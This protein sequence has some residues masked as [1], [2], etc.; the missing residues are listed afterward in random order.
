VTSGGAQNLTADTA[1]ADQNREEAKES[2]TLPANTETPATEVGDATTGDAD[3]HDSVDPDDEKAIDEPVESQDFDAVAPKGGQKWKRGLACGV[4]PGL[5]LLLAL[6]AGF[7][8][9]QDSSI[10]AGEVAR[11]ESMQVAKDATVRLLSYRPDTVDEDLGAARELLAGDF[12][13][14][15]TS[16]INDVVIPGAKQKQISAVASVPAAASIS[17]D[18]RHAE[19]VVFVDQTVIVGNDAPTS[20]NSSIKVTLNKVDGRWLILKFD[21]V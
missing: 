6:G 18:P 9:W 7:L 10:R 17:A 13:N 5:A 15:Y 19:T 21:P 2:V 16:L 3:A 1:S 14:A 20:T 11:I 8:K 12:K 4:L